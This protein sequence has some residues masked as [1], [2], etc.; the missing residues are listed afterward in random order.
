MI[1]NNNKEINFLLDK[2]FYTLRRFSEVWKLDI[3]YYRKN[4]YF[5]INEY[6]VE[7]LKY[8]TSELLDN[9]YNS[10]SI[11]FPFI[12]ENYFELD[13]SAIQYLQTHWYTF[14]SQKIV[15]ETSWNVEEIIS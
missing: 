12:L 13:D 7:M 6:L 10:D 9:W 1:N 3:W 8:A 14:P 11:S 5:N 15:N 4:G 2:V